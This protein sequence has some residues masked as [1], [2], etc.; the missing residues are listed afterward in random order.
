MKCDGRKGARRENPGDFQSELISGR[1]LGGYTEMANNPS[2]RPEPK[3]NGEGPKKRRHRLPEDALPT[4]ELAVIKERDP[5]AFDA[6][7][8]WL[9][10]EGPDPWKSGGR[11]S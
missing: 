5:V 4:K 2:Y 8:A 3:R 9:N 1:T 7:V 10:G 11:E 6:A